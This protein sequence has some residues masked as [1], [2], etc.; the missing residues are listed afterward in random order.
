MPE[1]IQDANYISLRTVN[2]E[3]FYFYFPPYFYFPNK[4]EICYFPFSS[5]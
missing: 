1:N 3:L 2:M 5:D 4:W